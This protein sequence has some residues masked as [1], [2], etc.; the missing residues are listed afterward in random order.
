MVKTYIQPGNV[1]TLAA[2][3][4]VKS[5]DPLHIGAF[6][7]V[8]MYDASSGDDVEV[9]LVGAKA[10]GACTETVLSTATTVRVRL[11]G[12]SILPI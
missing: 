9:G 7:G 1:I 8:A 2:A 12:A 4:P 5:G 6:F 11:N 10:A 3:G